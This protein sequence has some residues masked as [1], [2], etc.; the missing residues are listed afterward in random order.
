MTSLVHPEVI[1]DLLSVLVA[2]ESAKDEK[3]IKVCL[4]VY[5]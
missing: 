2:P 3:G 5:I 1:L 4:K